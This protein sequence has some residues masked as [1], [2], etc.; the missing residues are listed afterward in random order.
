M[1]V[2]KDKKR[3]TFYFSF[4][5]VVDG[6]TISKTGRGF[7]TKTAATIAELKA[8]DSLNKPSIDKIKFS[9]LFELFLS[10][11]QTK[12]KISTIDSYKR[13]YKNH[14][15]NYFGS[16]FVFSISSD[17][18]YQWKNEIILKGLNENF[19]NS[20]L[21]LMRMLITLAI[22]KNILSDNSLL[23]ELES[24][25]V[26]KLA[27]ERQVLTLKEIDQFLDS[28][29]KSDSK[30]YAYYLYFLGLANS[31]MRPNEY[32][33]LQVKD[34]QDDYLIVNKSI[35]SKLGKGDIIQPPKTP[36]S[37]RKV[38]MPHYIIELLLDYTKDYDP[39]DFI[40]GKDKPFRETTIQR[41]LDK[42]IQ[43]CNLPH[44]VVYSFRHSHATNLIKAGVPIKVVSK[45]L[46]HTN[47][48]T[49]MNVYW[50]LFNDD[51][52]QVLNIL[53]K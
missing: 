6:K 19:I 37:N 3:G 13:I 15:S 35:T 30:E 23:N 11:Q 50:H 52:K 21:T 48:S 38:L 20:I 32:R 40:F 42:H 25:R 22:R 29:I 26:H 4:K 28:F 9:D 41:Y 43:V 7:T 8:L 14:I 17:N 24:V 12:V 53:E 31:G 33:C 10:Y 39:N 44:I 51:E 36:S 47:A 2:Y 49:T 5:R 45:R 16:K 34:I 1:P 46:G 27:P 18:L